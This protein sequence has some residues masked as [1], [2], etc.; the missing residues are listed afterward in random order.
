MGKFLISWNISTV[1]LTRFLLNAVFSRNQNARK[2]ENRYKYLRKTHTGCELIVCAR[3]VGRS[4]NPWVPV[5][6]WWSWLRSAKIWGC[7]S[8]DDRPVCHILL[9][10]GF[11]LLP[12]LPL[13]SAEPEKS[14]NVISLK[15]IHWLNSSAQGSCFIWQ[16]MLALARLERFGEKDTFFKKWRSCRHCLQSE[17]ALGRW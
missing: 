8:R 16:L 3:A 5:V 7:Y 2:S 15:S 4:E 12:A 11:F 1:P 9:N 17:S 13:I 14:S 10:K 6:M